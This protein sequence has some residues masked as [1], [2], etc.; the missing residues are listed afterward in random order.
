MNRSEH[1]YVATVAQDCREAALEYGL[2]LESDAF[3]TALNLDDPTAVR[4]ELSLMGS[5]ERRV[6][7]GPFNE[8]CPAAIDP[9]VREITA[10]RYAQ[11][12]DM[13]LRMGASKLVIHSGFIPLIYFPE[14]FIGQSVLFWKEFF[15]E[16]AEDIT[17]CLENVLEGDLAIPREIVREVNDPR[18][19]LCLDVGHVHCNPKAQPVETWIRNWAPW[20]SHVHLHNNDRSWDT[21]SGLDQGTIPM[22]ET[23]EL[24]ATLAPG[25]TWTLETLEARP[26]CRW[27]REHHWIEE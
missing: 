13:A 24:L 21:H 14:W 27:L 6:L 22:E 23:L 4:E 9:L 11:A 25:A 20:L 2:G 8:L 7:H 5:V 12:W 10:R 15:R 17:V 19:R 18:L 26:A 3:C 1:I 16:R